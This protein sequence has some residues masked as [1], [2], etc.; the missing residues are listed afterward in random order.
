MLGAKAL[1]RLPIGLATAVPQIKQKSDSNIQ[2]KVLEQNEDQDFQ[3]RVKRNGKRVE[4]YLEFVKNKDKPENTT[5]KKPKTRPTSLKIKISDSEI[6]EEKS[7]PKKS[8][9]SR[10]KT[11]LNKSVIV[12]RNSVVQ[13]NDQTEKSEWMPFVKNV[14]PDKKSTPEL[15]V[16]WATYFRSKWVVPND[17]RLPPEMRKNKKTDQLKL[18]QKVE[19]VTYV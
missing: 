9:K 17:S 2:E 6:S 10:N 5:N 13:F 7:I 18:L 1:V 11:V 19:I 16:D 3:D 4:K 12:Y 14:N 8:N 15:K